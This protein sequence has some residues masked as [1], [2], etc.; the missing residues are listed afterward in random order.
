[1]IKRVFKI[2]HREVDR[3]FP[4]L[5]RGHRIEQK[6]DI[7]NGNIL[8]LA[9]QLVPVDKA[10]KA[11][12]PER[13][14]QDKDLGLLITLKLI[15]ESHNIEYFAVCG[16]LLGAVRHRGFIPWDDDMDLGMLREDYD[17]F[18]SL[19]KTDPYRELFSVK[20][21]FESGR[22]GPQWIQMTDQFGGYTDVFPYDLFDGEERSVLQK[23]RGR[24]IFCLKVLSAFSGGRIPEKRFLRFQEKMGVKGLKK[25]NASSNTLVVS[26]LDHLLSECLKYGDFFPLKEMDFESEQISVPRDPAKSLRGLYLHWEAY[27]SHIRGHH[28]HRLME[29]LKTMT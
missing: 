8:Y 10:L 15:F 9:E 3:L 27:P 18:I 1:M 26:G 19:L 29:Y 14:L 21:P 25:A 17:R 7:L 23:R 6:L 22:K 16:T 28:T 24:L 20:F 2:L 12:G 13:E 11:T 4:A 5:T